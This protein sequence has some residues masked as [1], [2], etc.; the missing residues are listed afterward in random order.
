MVALLFMPRTKQ[1]LKDV[2]I[3]LP[4]QVAK[5]F[6]LAHN[7]SVIFLR[8]SIFYIFENYVYTRSLR[9]HYIRFSPQKRA[10]PHFFKKPNFCSGHKFIALREKCE[11]SSH[12]MLLKTRKCLIYQKTGQHQLFFEF[13]IIM[14]EVKENGCTSTRLA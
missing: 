12:K 2:W 8:E 10:E 7:K 4:F 14:E 9:A 3:K 13:F 1:F 11:C 5:K 6:M